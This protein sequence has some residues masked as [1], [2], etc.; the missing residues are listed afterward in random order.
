ML[1]QRHRLFIACPKKNCEI[2]TIV[3]QIAGKMNYPPQKRKTVKE[4]AT[5]ILS[6]D[7]RYAQTQ[8]ECA[9]NEKKNIFLQ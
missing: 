7:G 5:G 8:R 6:T 4:I 3:V 2:F 1:F 9:T